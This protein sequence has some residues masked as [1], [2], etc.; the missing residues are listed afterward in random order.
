MILIHGSDSSL[1][2]PVVTKVSVV[3]MEEYDVG[4]VT[5]S[6]VGDKTVS[7]TVESVYV[8]PCVSL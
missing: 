7:V 3:A 5:L 8:P 4:I 6:T 2:R 1:A